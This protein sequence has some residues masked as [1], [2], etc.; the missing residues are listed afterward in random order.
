MVIKQVLW[1][2]RAH[3][4]WGTRGDS[5]E[6]ASLIPLMERNWDLYLQLPSETGCKL[7]LKGNYL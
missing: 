6:H 7:L 2:T 1:A 4:H 5:G 3:S